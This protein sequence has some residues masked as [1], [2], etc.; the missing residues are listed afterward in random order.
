MTS[1]FIESELKKQSLAQGKLFDSEEGAQEHIAD[2]IKTYEL[3]VNE[4]VS[5]LHK[6]TLKTISPRTHSAS[7]WSL[8]QSDTK[9]STLSSRDK[10]A[11]LRAAYR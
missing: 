3:E 4:S 10:Y 5:T 11:Y 8:T 7:C 2:F 9:P 6:V 1:S